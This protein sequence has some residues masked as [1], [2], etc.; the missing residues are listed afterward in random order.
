MET[1]IP[2]RLELKKAP[3]TAAE[4]RKF[5]FTVG[6]AFLVIGGVLL[7]RQH[8]IKS[9]VAFGLGGGLTLGGLVV[10][11]LLGPV[12]KAWMGLAHLISKVTTPLFMGIVYFIVMMP[13]GSIR[14]NVGNGSPIFRKPGKSQWNAHEPADG[15]QM[16]RQF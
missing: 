6:L 5:G 1:G 14:K 10:P 13:I 4:G 2:A 8:P 12:E 11:T 16:E 7:W 9:Y 3:M 15:A